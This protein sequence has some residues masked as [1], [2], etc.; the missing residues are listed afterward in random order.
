M[1]PPDGPPVWTALNGRPSMIPPPMSKMISRRVMPIGTSTRPVFTT[2][3][4]RA[5]TFV[6][7]L[8]PIRDRR[9]PVRALAQDRRHVGEGLDVVDQG[10]AVEQARD[11]RVRRPRPRIAALALDRGDER[12]LLAAHERPGTEADLHVEGE[13]RV[14]DAGTEPAGPLGLPD[15]G[16]QAGDGERVLRAAVDVALGGVDREGGDRHAL[17]DAVGVA[18]E[19]AAVHERPGVALVGIADDVLLRALRL[20][21]GGPLE[22]GRVARPAATAETAA[23]DL[24]ADLGGGH[25]GQHPL[26]RLV[27]APLDVVV[28]ALG[29]HPADVLGRDAELALEERRLRPAACRPA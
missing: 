27:A 26:E 12:R 3:P 7:R 11:G 24:L 5:N 8:L 19:D 2:R 22:G 10:R 17:E 23:G 15:R 9:V 21:D 25:L 18:L 29:V 28:E 20:G 16:P 1:Q 14:G 4:A 6:P 13:R